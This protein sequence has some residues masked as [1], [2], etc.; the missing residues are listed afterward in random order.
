M[1]SN[2]DQLKALTRN[3][4]P[5]GRANAIHKGGVKDKV[6]NALAV[7]QLQAYE[8]AKSILNVILPDNNNFTADDATR[9]EERLG[10]ITNPLVSLTDRKLAI[11]RKM[12]HPGDI[13]ARQSRDYLQDS[14]RLAGFDV[15][16]Y[17]NTLDQ[18][19]EQVLSINNNVAQWGVKQFG[20]FNFGSI[21]NIYSSLFDVDGSGVYHYNQKVVNNIDP[22]LD[23][24]FDIGTTNKSIF[25]IGGV[26][27]G[28]FANV[29]T[30]RREEFR[31]LILK[32]KP[33]QTV[34][35]LLVNY[36]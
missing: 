17:E 24:F 15:Y 32:I 10:L 18:N 1:S 27:L 21:Y 31:Q 22:S 13:P 5:T 9:W 23:T 4:L 20:N 28:S 34:G 3:L 36:I 35:Y 11:I 6:Y 30:N 2:L 19:I 16:V 26:T 29:D 33:V 12:N 25:F 7:S 8:D 14:L